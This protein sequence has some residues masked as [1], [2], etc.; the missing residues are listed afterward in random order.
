MYAIKTS[1]LLDAAQ[2]GF[3]QTMLGLLEEGADKDTAD[4]VRVD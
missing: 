2:S 4:E 1:Q 3:P